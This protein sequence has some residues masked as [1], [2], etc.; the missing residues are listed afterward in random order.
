[1]RRSLRPS[2]C[3]L[4]FIALVGLGLVAVSP[5]VTLP[6]FAPRQA[7]AVASPDHVAF[8]GV[9][10]SRAPGGFADLIG[11]LDVALVAAAAWALVLDVATPDAAPLGL[12]PRRWRARLEGAPPV[13]A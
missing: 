10:D 11:L 6:R 12:G 3:L 5:A 13:V 9:I 8:V 7:R 1:M 4:G 2:S